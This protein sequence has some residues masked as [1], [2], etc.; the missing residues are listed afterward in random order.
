MPK[1]SVVMNCYNSEA[2]LRQA[3]DS[4]YAQTFHDWEIIFW[5]NASTDGSAA[6]ARSFDSRLRYFRGEKTVPL[7]AARKLAM[8]KARGEWIGFLDCDDYWLPH[9]LETQ[10][11][12]LEKTDHV[13]CYG[14]IRMQRLD[15]SFLQDQLPQQPTGWIL[16]QQLHQ[17]DIN[18]VTPL[19][20]RRTLQQFGIDFDPNVTASEEYNLF[21]RLLAKG[22]VC[23]VPQVLGVWRVG[24]QSLTNR[25]MGNWA[26]ER[27]YTLDHV[28]TENPGI[29]VR[30]PEAFA[31]AYARGT[32][33]HARY[34][35]AEGKL[36]EAREEMGKIRA[37]DRRYNLLWYA[38]FIPPLWHLLHRPQLRL[39]W[40]PRLQAIFTSR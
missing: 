36:L 28:K 27:F 14:G 1:V 26:R 31:V 4:V 16:E 37:L 10:I 34:L 3:I 9:K 39:K 12:A 38:L 40:L 33:Y 11:G 29:D 2:F 20:R 30:Y 5:D 7:G 22:S 24:D 23:V 8:E 25:A 15:G 21:T 18:M 19:I 13:L 17:F 35:A 6:I 32:Y